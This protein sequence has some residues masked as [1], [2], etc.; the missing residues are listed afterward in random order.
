VIAR[1][2]L[3][4]GVVAH[5]KSVDRCG[6]IRGALAPFTDHCSIWTRSLARATAADE[7]ISNVQAV[8]VALTDSAGIDAGVGTEAVN[9]TSSQPAGIEHRTFG[10]GFTRLGAALAS[11]ALVSR[12]TLSHGLNADAVATTVQDAG[13]IFLTTA[14]A[15]VGTGCHADAVLTKLPVVTRAAAVILSS[16]QPRPGKEKQERRQRGPHQ[17]AP[18]L[19]G[20]ERASKR[21]YPLVHF[22]PLPRGRSFLAREAGFVTSWQ[23]HLWLGNARLGTCVSRFELRTKSV[24]LLRVRAR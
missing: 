4:A 5:D 23:C 8:T 17:P 20:T 10:V 9:I 18:V 14:V 21:V 13:I 19:Q 11:A 12:E 24:N 22:I 3:S 16:S 6:S 7:T 2:N 15:I 1:S